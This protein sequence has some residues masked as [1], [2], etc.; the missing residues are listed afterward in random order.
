MCLKENVASISCPPRLSWLWIHISY[1]VAED[2]FCVVLSCI[3][4]SIYD[5]G[6]LCLYVDSMLCS[7]DCVYVHILVVVS[8]LHMVWTWSLTHATF[9]SLV[10]RKKECTTYIQ[11]AES[12]CIRDALVAVGARHFLLMFLD[13]CFITYYDMRLLNLIRV[14]SGHGF[15]LLR[16]YFLYKL[17]NRFIYHLLLS[18]LVQHKIFMLWCFYD[19]ENVFTNPCIYY[20]KTITF[21]I[22]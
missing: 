19:W 14:T 15:I 16:L 2:R 4:A 11:I 10:K 3:I 9:F 8:S 17:Y 22:Y 12:R 1:S 7:H 21:S 18:S 13:C 6:C 5:N 20:A